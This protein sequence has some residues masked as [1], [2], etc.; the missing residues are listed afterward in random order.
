VHGHEDRKVRLHH[1]SLAT[2]ALGNPVDLVVL[3]TAA[4]ENKLAQ[5]A[6]AQAKRAVERAV[7]A[8]RE[9]TATEAAAA[10]AAPA[11][12]ADDD[13]QHQ[14]PHQV[15]RR[16]SRQDQREDV[17]RDPHQDP[18]QDPRQEQRQEQRQDLHQRQR[19]Q[20]KHE[21]LLS[22][23]QLVSSVQAGPSRLDADAVRAELDALRPPRA[24]N[25]VLAVE[26][27]E[28]LARK[29][30]EG[31]TNAQLLG[32]MRQKREAD[33]AIAAGAA[34]TAASLETTAATAGTSPDE[35]LHHRRPSRAASKT[36]QDGGS[37]AGSTFAGAVWK[38][39][40]VGPDSQR[41]P[42]RYQELVRGKERTVARLLEQHWRLR[43]ADDAS[44][45]GQLELRLTPLELSLLLSDGRSLLSLLSGTHSP[46]PM[47]N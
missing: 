6:K 22:A 35:T 44:L 30:D 11:A 47:P 3:R 31:F 38:A 16:G 21:P 8:T 23:E 13:S 34:A 20:R 39:G 12:S 15:R 4:R 17:R 27:Y 45:V 1:A 41:S 9:S 37:G 43:R 25:G 18:R 29:I 46:P 7:A 42:K 36:S 24:G 10:A 40:L 26:D 5:D 14:D 32:Y 28:A 2:P 33:A 19:Q